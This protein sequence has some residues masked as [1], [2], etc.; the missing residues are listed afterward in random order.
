MSPDDALRRQPVWSPDASRLAYHL[1][2]EQSANVLV[3]RDRD[4]RERLL[5]RG[6]RQNGYVVPTHWTPDGRFVVASAR[7]AGGNVS[8][9]LWAVDRTDQDKP[10][11]TL[12]SEPS[13]NLWQGHFS[14]DGRWVSFVYIDSEISVSAIAVVPS[15]GGDASRWMRLSSEMLVDK[16][17]WSHDGRSLYFLGRRAR[18][19]M[20]L[21]RIGFDPAAGRFV[22]AAEQLSNFSRPDLEISPEVGSTSYP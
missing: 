22:G 17:R 1:S 18:S 10:Y 14:P 21:F 15:E 8:I 11:R 9:G 19:Y 16:P 3:V 12:L 4:G 13:L 5:S 6:R 20:H 7:R 2:S